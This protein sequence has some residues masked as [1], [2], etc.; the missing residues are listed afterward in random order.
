[1]NKRKPQIR[2]G[3]LGAFGGLAGILPLS[4][5]GG[6]C[7]ACFGC[8]GIGLAIVLI[9]ITQKLGA[10]RKRGRLSDDQGR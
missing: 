2:Y 7:G 1:M 6:N 9:L 8:A 4:R 5:C 10:E 3:V